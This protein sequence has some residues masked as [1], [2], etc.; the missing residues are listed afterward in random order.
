M[1]GFETQLSKCVASVHNYQNETLLY[2]II[3]P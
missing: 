1:F 2:S 3:Y